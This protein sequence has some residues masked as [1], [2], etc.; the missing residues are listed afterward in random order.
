M[1]LGSFCKTCL[2]VKSL[3]SQTGSTGASWASQL[4]AM[5][6]KHVAIHGAVYQRLW[7]LIQDQ[8]RKMDCLSIPESNLLL[9]ISSHDVEMHYG[10]VSWSLLNKHLSIHWALYHRLFGALI[11][12]S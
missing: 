2:A 5:L 10:E 9:G 7:S 6:S 8:V 11:D 3:E 12:H 1:I 4:V